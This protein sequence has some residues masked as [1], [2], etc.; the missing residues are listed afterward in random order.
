M[1]VSSWGL[2]KNRDGSER[3]HITDDMKAGEGVMSVIGG[4]LSCCAVPP[5]SFVR[6]DVL[7]GRAPS[8]PDNKKGRPEAALDISHRDSLWY[9]TIEETGGIPKTQHRGILSRGEASGLPRLRSASLFLCPTH[10]QRLRFGSL[11]SRGVTRSCRSAS[12]FPPHNPAVDDRP[13]G[14]RSIITGHQ[15]ETAGSSAPFS[16]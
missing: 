4:L 8:Y 2:L 13:H 3:Q 1:R 15:Q 7:W 10:P 14:T 9:L 12:R 6:E 11:L 5:C 16:S